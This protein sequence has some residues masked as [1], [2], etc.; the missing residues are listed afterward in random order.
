VRGDIADPPDL[1]ESLDIARA[2]V[3]REDKRRL[4]E[5]LSHERR[6]ARVDAGAQRFGEKRIAVVPDDHRTDIRCRR[7][8]RRPI[9]DDDRGCSPRRRRYVA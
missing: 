1:D 2:G 3:P 8:H 5:L 7:I 6:I 9:A 4:F